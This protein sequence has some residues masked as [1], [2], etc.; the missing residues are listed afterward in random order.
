MYLAITALTE[1]H[2]VRMQVAQNLR[3]VPSV[4]LLELWQGEELV[5]SLVQQY[6][7]S[8]SA[9]ITLVLFAVVVVE[10]LDSLPLWAYQVIIV[11]SVPEVSVVHYC[12]VR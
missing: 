1:V 9:D 11:I 5:A 2:H 3:R 7:L 8:R 10:L 4:A 6:P 12:I